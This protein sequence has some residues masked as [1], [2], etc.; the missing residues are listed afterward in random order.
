MKLSKRLTTIASLVPNGIPCADIGSDHGLLISFLMDNKIVPYAYASDNKK[1]PYTKLLD[2]LSK[3]NDFDKIEVSLQDGLNNLPNKYKTIIIAGM[4][5]ELIQE[6][7]ESSYEKLENIDY[8]LLA[9]HGREG[10]LRKYL[11]DKGFYIYDEEIVFEDHYYEIILFK[12]GNKSYSSY[13]LEYGPILLEKKSEVF[14]SKYK[15][16]IHA[17]KELLNNPY[18]IKDRIIDISSEIVEYQKL[19]SDIATGDE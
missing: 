12:K 4:G 13:Q 3:R 5:G 17:L 16:K 11:V 15:D 9:P 10:K 2:N 19:L 18:L 7:L 14:F 8:L 6:I 1:G